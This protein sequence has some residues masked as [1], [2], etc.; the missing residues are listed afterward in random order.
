M[1]TVSV[2]LTRVK[3]L[4][5][6]SKLLKEKKSQVI[7]DL[8]IEGRKM[9]AMEFYKEKKVSLGLGAKLAGVSLSEFLDLL[10]EYNISVNLE[11]EDAQSAMKF[12]EEIL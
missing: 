5:F 2:R 8:L 11:L 1:D 9:R 6:I 12:A 3:D 10:R 4:E 7:R